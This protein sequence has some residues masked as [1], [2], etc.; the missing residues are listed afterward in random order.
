MRPKAHEPLADVPEPLADADAPLLAFLNLSPTFLNLSWAFLCLSCLLTNLPSAVLRV[1]GAS[2]KR[3]AHTQSSSCAHAG[4]ATG[5]SA[6]PERSWP[7]E[8]MVVLPTSGR[9]TGERGAG[10]A[11]A[12]RR[13]VRGPCA[14][15]RRDVRR[16]AAHEAVRLPGRFERRTDLRQAEGAL[17]RRCAAVC[18]RLAGVG[19]VSTAQRQTRGLALDG[20]SVE[21]RVAARGGRAR[22]SGL[23]AGRRTDPSAATRACQCNDDREGGERDEAFDSVAEVES[24][25]IT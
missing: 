8:L 5:R 16:G 25:W 11:L 3:S 6:G 14:G 7:A 19:A 13:R 23:R 22:V 10:P 4:R 17:A 20:C 21:R 9:A 1:A 15:V 2:L 24:H 12:E 18:V